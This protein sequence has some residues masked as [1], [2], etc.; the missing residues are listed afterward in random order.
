[1]ATTIGELLVKL[2]ADLK[3]LEAG[4]GK[5]RSELSG[6]KSY[7]EGFASSLKKTLAFAGVAVGLWEIAG[8]LKSFSKEAAMTGARTETLR[9]AMEQV[10]KNAGLSA[11]SLDYFVERLKTAGITTQEAMLGVT[12]FMV[13]GLDLTKLQELATRARDI[14]VVANVNT[15]EA[16]SRLIQGIISGETEMLRRLMVNVG[17]IDD[18]L[19]RHAQTL[20]IEKDQIDAVTRANIVLNAVLEASARFAGAAAA[21]DATVGKQLAS[22]SRYAEEAKNA[23]WALFQPV[24]LAG[25]KSMSQ[26]WKDLEVWAKANQAT[27][28]Q[29]GQAMGGFIVDLAKATRA[30]IEFVAEFKTLLKLLAELWI[31]S[32]IAGAF[33]GLAAGL[34]TAAAEVG[35]LTALLLRLKALIGGPWKLIITISLVG[36]YEAWKEIQ[37]LGKE[38]PWASES[39]PYLGPK[40]KEGIARDRDRQAQEYGEMTLEWEARRRGITKEELDRIL[41]ENLKRQ[42]EKK[43]LVDLPPVLQGQETPQEKAEREA[44]EAKKKAEEEAKA[45][46]GPGKEPKGK[47]AAE[48]ST[49]DLLAM[50][51]AYLDQKQQKEIQAAEES[52]ATFKAENDKKKAELELA[53]AEGKITGKQ[54]YAALKEM[55]QAETELALALIQKKIAAENQAYERAKAAVARSDASPEAQELELAKLREAHE[56]RIIQLKGEAG[57]IGI[58]NAKKLIDLAKQEF[59]NRKRIEDMLASGRE[60]AALGPVAEKEAEINRLLRE[61]LKLRKELIQ[62]GGSPEQVGAFDRATRELEIN[63]RFGDQIKAYT[64]L[65]SSFFGDMVD[66]IMSGEKDLRQSLNRFFKSLF[67]QALEPAMKQ[68]MQWLT[69]FF[70][71]LFGILGEAILSSVMAI[72]A[73]VGMFLT[74][75]GGSSWTPSSVQG[76]VTG[77]EAVRG[78]IAGETS[79]PIAQVSESLEEALIPTNSILRQIEANTRSLGG[80]AS[81]SVNIQGLQ[82]AVAEA[83]ERYF[84]EYLMM[85]AGA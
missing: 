30:V 25:V 70:K 37:R 49:E 51:D 40:I 69:D 42:A 47:G 48:K 71:Q 16:F 62:L 4:L 61:R 75:G 3:S 79:I 33:V 50:L 59:E 73:M 57:R 77:H 26:A 41:K 31:A 8:A 52:F 32:K 72:V 74:S 67:K 55:Q 54:Y 15:S 19:K 80:G 45:R 28:A 84:R 27:L 18:L 66:A 12:K 9:V 20:G 24:M 53:L 34:R 11:Q 14:A 6:F 78:I 58:E 60:E 23:L 68:M 7:A 2:S 81:V 43:P 29:Y 13:A 22:L 36:L 64:N 38:V 1:M 21:A 85:G 65:I 76:G 39:G 10:G 44:A 17:H 5:A 63:K 82:E 35:I 56:M 46:L 83:M